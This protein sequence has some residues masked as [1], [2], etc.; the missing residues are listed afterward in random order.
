MKKKN[1]IHSIILARGGSKG[2]K[3]KNLK[4]IKDKPLIFWSIKIIE[5][6]K[7]N[8]TWVSSDSEKILKYAKK[9]GAL[10]IKDQNHYH[11]ILRVPKPPGYMLQSMLKKMV[12]K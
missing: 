3:N 11:Q 9:N 10:I 6:K 8:Y 7:I 4:L 2:I 5:I 1:N 12:T